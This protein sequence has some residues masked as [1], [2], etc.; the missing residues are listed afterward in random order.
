MCLSPIITLRDVRGSLSPGQRYEVDAFALQP[1]QQIA[2][3][4]KSGSGKST[5]LHLISGMIGAAQGSV[6]VIGQELRGMRAAQRD[7]LRRD[8]IGMIFQ[9]YQLLPEFTVLENVCMG[10]AFSPRAAQ[11]ADPI[12]RALLAKVGLEG[13]EQRRPAQLSVGQQQRVAIARA[14]IK[15][16][17]ILLADEPTGALDPETGASI[18]Q[19]IQQLATEHQSTLVF[20][21]H[22]HSLAQRLPQQIDVESLL[23]W[24]SAPTTAPARAERGE[25]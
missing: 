20:V 5:L 17:A 9:S 2:L 18:C 16:P 3:L 24:S 4:G 25:A 19:L 23:H 14:L 6:Q 15:K 21:T 12:A 1:G 7:R 22:D 8:H 11:Q 10:L 13:L